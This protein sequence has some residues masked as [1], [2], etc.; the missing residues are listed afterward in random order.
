MS[1]EWVPFVRSLPCRL[2]TALL[3]SDGAIPASTDRL[4][5]FVG[6]RHPV[7]IL[8]VSFSVASQQECPR[9]G[10][11]NQ[12]YLIANPATTIHQEHVPRIKIIPLLDNRYGDCEAQS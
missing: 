7:I 12:I 8:Q 3:M 1:I 9:R 6:F 4:L 10:R 2:A 11:G 5:V